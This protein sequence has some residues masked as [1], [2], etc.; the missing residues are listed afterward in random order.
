VD[1]C[2]WVKQC[3]SGIVMM[4]INVDKCLTIGSDKVIKEIIEDLKK[5]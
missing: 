5:I 2:L 4:S 1:L 3:N